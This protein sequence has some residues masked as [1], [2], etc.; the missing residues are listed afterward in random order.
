M[1]SATIRSSPAERDAFQWRALR[2]RV[3]KALLFAAANE[4]LLTCFNAICAQANCLGCVDLDRLRCQIKGSLPPPLTLARCSVQ[5]SAVCKLV[6]CRPHAYLASSG[7]FRC[8]S[9]IPKRRR[10]LLFAKAL[11]SDLLFPLTQNAARL[12]IAPLKAETGFDSPRERQPSYDCEP[13]LHRLRSATSL[14]SFG[15]FGSAVS[16]CLPKGNAPE[17]SSCFRLVVRVISQRVRVL[18]FLGVRVVN[19]IEQRQGKAI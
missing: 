15:P 10:L 18:R 3:R 16:W 1:I 19:G 14:N 17:R 7:N 9:D 2:R 12:G 4:V 5:I 8:T 6:A 11:Y 13:K